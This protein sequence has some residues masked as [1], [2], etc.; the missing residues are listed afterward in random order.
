MLKQEHSRITVISIISA[1]IV[2]GNIFALTWT[3]GHNPAW[4]SAILTLVSLTSIFGWVVAIALF[5]E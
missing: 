2:V 5:T 3:W 1:I 4:V